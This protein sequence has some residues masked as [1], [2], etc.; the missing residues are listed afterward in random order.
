[1]FGHLN[2]PYYGVLVDSIAN[3]YL[4]THCSYSPTSPS[5]TTAAIIASTYCDYFGSL[6]YP[7]SVTC[8]LRVAKLGNSSVVYEVG[9][10]VEGEEEVK[11]VGGS[12]HVWVEK[13]SDGSLGRALKGGMPREVRAGYEKLMEEEVGK[14]KL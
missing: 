10:F 8:G 13:R 6:A 11:A 2:N 7:G 9:F 4:I 14:A 5:Q 1:M 3:A 12:M